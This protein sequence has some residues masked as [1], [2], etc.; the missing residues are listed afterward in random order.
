MTSPFFFVTMNATI[1]GVMPLDRCRTD[2]SPRTTL[3]PDGWNEYRLRPVLLVQ[4]MMHGPEPAGSVP[5]KSEPASQF[6]PL[7]GSAQPPPS[8]PKPE[9][10]CGLARAAALIDRGPASDFA[11]HDGIRGAV[12]DVGDL[13]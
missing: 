9:F 3:T 7:P 12:S 1:L 11:D 10:G 2:P 5:S 13:T 4:L 8:V 6:S